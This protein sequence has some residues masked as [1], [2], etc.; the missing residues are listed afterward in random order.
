M[1]PDAAEFDN[2]LARVSGPLGLEVADL[3]PG[4]RERWS[5]YA[6]AHGWTGMDWLD[7]PGVLAWRRD[8]PGI[9]EMTWHQALDGEALDLRLMPPEN[10][11][12]WRRQV[13][14]LVRDIGEI[15][16]RE[17]VL[18]DERSATAVLRFDPDR[19]EV[20]VPRRPA[21]RPLDRPPFE[22]CCA[23]MAG[24]FA[25][26]CDTCP[27]PRDCPDQLLLYIP[28]GGGGSDGGEYGLPVRDGGSAYVAIAFCPWC[29]SRVSPDARVAADD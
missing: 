23:A 10:P 11:L 28:G 7:M 19:H 13:V 29:G 1:A 3:D 14:D 12:V 27:D 20:R 24:Q 6:T 8:P 25:E 18:V 26:Q 17:V 5:V 16:R 4:A 15:L 22:P 9:W 2:V 21:V